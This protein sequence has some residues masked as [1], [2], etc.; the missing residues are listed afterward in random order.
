MCNM[1]K[2]DENLDSRSWKVH[3]QLFH[4]QFSEFSFNHSVHF[5]KSPMLRLSGVYCSHSFKPIASKLHINHVIRGRLLRFGDLP[6][7][8]VYVT[9]KLSY[10]SQIGIIHKS[11]LVSSGKWSSRAS[12]SL[13]LLLYTN[14]CRILLRQYALKNCSQFTCLSVNCA[15]YKT[16]GNQFPCARQRDTVA[17]VSQF[18]ELICQLIHES[19]YHVHHLR[20]PFS[21][22]LHF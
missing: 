17:I 15:R 5:T 22:K 4:V 7:F 1:L 18:L 10:L 6:N 2:M 9:L 21:F 11:I 19:L 14:R 13:G 16:N 3:M 20:K 12:R 8:K